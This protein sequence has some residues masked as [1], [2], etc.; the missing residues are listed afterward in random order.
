MKKII[1]AIDL[2]DGRV[3]RL[4]QGDF[5]AITTYSKDASAVL[6]YFAKQGFDQIHIINLNG[7]HSG[8]FE[9]GPNSALVYSLIEEGKKW[10]IKIQ[11]GGG[12]R[13]K[14]TVK[15]LLDIG[16]FKAIIGTIAIENQLLFKRL[17]KIF[18]NDIIVA[19]DVQNSTLN[20]HGWA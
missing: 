8:T 20:T 4:Y 16:L 9:L 7:A 13:T 10:G 6:R 14:N 2:Y 15:K 18:R 11:L 17:M 1:P 12:I 19:L 3:V 5:N